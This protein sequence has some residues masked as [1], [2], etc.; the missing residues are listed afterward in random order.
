MTVQY[1]YIGMPL[2]EIDTPVL[3]ADLDILEGNILRLASHFSAAGKQL[4]PHSKSHKTPA[5][6]HKQLEAGA[7]GIT[8]AKLGEAEVM[9]A[10]GIDDILIANEVVGRKKIERLM[11]LAG[12]CDIMV[13]IDQ[14]Q[15]LAEL[16]AAA[17]QQ[18]VRPRVLVE[19]NIGHNRCGAAP[20]GQAVELARLVAGA[21]HVRFAGLMGYEGHIVD[22]EDRTQREEGARECLQRLVDTR[23]AV[24][25]A[26]IA[27]EIC[28]A[29]GTGDY[30]ISTGFAGI[31]EVQAGSY[32]LMDAAYGKLELGFAQ[33]LTVLTTVC[34][35][36]GPDQVISDAGLKSVTPEHGMPLVKGRPDL[37]VHALSEEHGRMRALDGATAVQI[38]D[39]LEFIPGH[40]CTTMNLHDHIYA[41]RGGRLEEIWPI[42]GRGKVR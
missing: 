29:S 21:Q 36:R 4:R 2:A 11:E 23:Q 33:A 25:E 10:A 7:I 42:A 39:V 17:G 15:N 13:A 20:G 41:V 24:E 31:T 32:A 16:D 22:L 35:R 40:G 28:S 14:A 1:E 9:A 34:S 37:E 26:G 8:C 38:G 5:I 18:G 27:V 6:A 19:V 30:Y 3:V 12:R